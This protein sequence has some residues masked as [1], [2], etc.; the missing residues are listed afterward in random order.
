[1]LSCWEQSPDNRPKFSDLVE[2]VNDL[3]KPLAGYL[4]VTEFII[5]HNNSDETHEDSTDN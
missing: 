3:I 5:T 1:M 2:S 4:D